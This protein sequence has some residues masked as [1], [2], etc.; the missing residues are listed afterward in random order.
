MKVV[1]ENQRTEYFVEHYLT[2]IS[3][4]RCENDSIEVL[5]QERDVDTLRVVLQL[6]PGQLQLQVL[7]LQ[8]GETVLDGTGLHR[9][10]LVDHLGPPEHPRQARRRHEQRVVGEGRGD[11]VLFV[12]LLL[13]HLPPDKHLSHVVQRI[14]QN[15]GRDIFPVELR[16]F[17]E[18]CI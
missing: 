14:L 9:L 16:T 6:P 10:R 17:H 11:W 13:K 1:P 3:I 15:L 12:F 8:H 5:S 2:L 4:L 7:L 18:D